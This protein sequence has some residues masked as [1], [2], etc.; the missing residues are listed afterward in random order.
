MPNPGL[1]DPNYV[2]DQYK[3]SNNLDA[4]I[5]L[6]ARFS[7][8]TRDFHEWV[9]DHF[10]FPRNARILEIGCGTGLLWQ[11]NRA[12]INSTWRIVLTDLS[13]GMLATS[14]E[15]GITAS[16]AETDAQSI[17]F[18]DATFDAIIA[19]HMLYHVPDLPRA[20]AEFQRVLKPGGKLF[21]ATNGSNHL[22]ELKN[23][24]SE[25]VSAEHSPLINQNITKQFSLDNGT[26]QLGIFFNHVERF[27]F[28]DALVVTEVEPLIA[29]T[30]SGFI[31]TMIKPEQI[32]A[33]R[34][35]A[36]ERIMRDGAI[37]I[38]KST[39]LFIANNH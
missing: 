22:D 3:A 39:G 36:T 38:T 6:H 28:P 17:P 2:R 9:F 19:N 23:W 35:S 21:A 10:D 26:E 20:L 14:R 1:N 12:R 7:T 32:D 30:T 13:F 27:D 29:Y 16:S 25:Y 11:K 34:Q 5:A 37:R 18:A 8:S 4:R 33:L 15:T 24:V 31:G